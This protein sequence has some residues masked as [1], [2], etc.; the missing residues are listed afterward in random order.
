M[1]EASEDYCVPEKG[2]QVWG[3]GLVDKCLIHN[4]DNLNLDSWNSHQKV[5]VV[6]HICNSS[7]P[8][9]VIWE[10]AETMGFGLRTS[11]EVRN[12]F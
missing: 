9:G 8:K 6:A 4:P 12:N 1:L 3:N 7:I 2:E 10:T 11:C 5:D